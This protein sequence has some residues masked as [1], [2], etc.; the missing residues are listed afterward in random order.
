VKVFTA[1][2]S[3]PIGSRLVPLRAPTCYEAAAM[4]RSRT[5]ARTL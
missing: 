1:G 3:T 5:K 2:A 4:T